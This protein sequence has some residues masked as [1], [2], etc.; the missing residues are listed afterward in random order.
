VG[1]DLARGAGAG[2]RSTQGERRADR[3]RAGARHGGPGRDRGRRRA[4]DRDRRPHPAGLGLFFIA[5]QQDP[6]LGFIPIQQR[7]ASLDSL[8][9]YIRHTGSAVFACPPGL[10]LDGWWG[11]TL[12][13]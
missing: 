2:H 4:A 11:D 12:F 13:T 3:S 8:N 10:G 5:F 7:L 1:P 9:E 6:R